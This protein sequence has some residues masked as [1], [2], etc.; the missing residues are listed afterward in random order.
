MVSKKR[1]FFGVGTKEMKE[2]KREEKERKRRR[3]E[4]EGRKGKE[5]RKEREKTPAMCAQ[6]L[7]PPLISLALEEEGY[8]VIREVIGCEVGVK[9]F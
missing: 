5:D 7:S 9:T 8:H 2:R 3:K 4:G 6:G 1:R